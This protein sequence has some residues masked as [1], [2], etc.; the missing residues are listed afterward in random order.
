MQQVVSSMVDNSICIR[1]RGVIGSNIDEYH[2][3]HI[4][5]HIFIW[6]RI[7]I[8]M[9]LDTNTN[10]DVLDANMDTRVSNTKIVRHG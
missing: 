3:H 10:T 2:R 5:F 8:R 6:V 9:A 7:R 4:C 1:G